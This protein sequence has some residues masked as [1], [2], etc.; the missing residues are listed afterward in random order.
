MTRHIYDA[1]RI[2]DITGGCGSGN[3]EG[4]YVRGHVSK[5]D[6][7]CAIAYT[8]YAVSGRNL[9]VRREWWRDVPASIYDPEWEPCETGYEP[10]IFDECDETTPGAYPV[11]VVYR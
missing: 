6:L 3:T 10:M 1:E 8:G 11:T 4:Y 7:L 2:E 9:D 5:L